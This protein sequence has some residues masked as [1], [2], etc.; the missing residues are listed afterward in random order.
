M[1]VATYFNF[2]VDSS[3][4]PSKSVYVTASIM[5]LLCPHITVSFHRA[6]LRIIQTHAASI[7]AHRLKTGTSACNKHM[8]G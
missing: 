2:S 5:L 4:N 1:Q 7:A 8:L 6:I 3:L